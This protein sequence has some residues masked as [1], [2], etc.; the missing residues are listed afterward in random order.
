MILPQYELMFNECIPQTRQTL[1]SIV[2]ENSY[3]SPVMSSPSLYSYIQI[4]ESM[5]A[6]SPFPR[7]SRAPSDGVRSQTQEIFTQ[8][9]LPLTTSRERK[10]PELPKKANFVITC[11]LLLFF[12]LKMFT[13]LITLLNAFQVLQ[14]QAKPLLS[15]SMY[16]ILLVGTES[17][18]ETFTHQLPPCCKYPFPP[19]GHYNLQDSLCHPNPCSALIPCLLCY[20]SDQVWRWEAR[21]SFTR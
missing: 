15:W 11:Y 7:P 20:T 8:Y 6:H 5:D 4:I 17:I 3:H 13:L 12:H 1:Q 19:I 2:W 21:W 9:W 10:V 16:C 14:S 18:L